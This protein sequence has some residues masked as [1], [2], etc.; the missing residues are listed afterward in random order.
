MKTRV[1]V[2][3]V[4]MLAL[5]TFLFTSGPTA[6]VSA[7]HRG[8]G[9]SLPVQ[10]FRVEIDGVSAAGIK[11]ITGLE[12]EVEVIEYR[13]GDNLIASKR[14]GRPK[15]NNVVLKRP[16]EG[17]SDLLAWHRAVVAGRA[18]RRSGSII[19]IGRDGQE[20]MRYNF[21]GAWPASWSLVQE[22]DERTGELQFLER[23]ELAIEKGEIAVGRLE[24]TR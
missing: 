11:E 19:Y 16:M 23:I 5:G 13:D 14:P 8:T 17:G 18:D 24:R 2:L 10:G 9:D 22:R 4:A 1:S 20:L 15:F 12:S 7:Q 21:S 3:A 6:T